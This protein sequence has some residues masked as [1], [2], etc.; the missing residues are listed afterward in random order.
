VVCYIATAIQYWRVANKVKCNTKIKENKEGVMTMVLA[1]S[2]SLGSFE[3]V[4]LVNGKHRN[5]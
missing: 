1:T 3:R 4:L 5:H 2:R